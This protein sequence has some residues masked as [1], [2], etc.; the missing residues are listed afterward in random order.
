MGARPHL[1]E[2]DR[3]AAARAAEAINLYWRAR[4]REVNAR[5]NAAG[6]IVSDLSAPAAV[7]AMPRRP[8]PAT[9]FDQN[10]GSDERSGSGKRSGRPA[11]VRAARAAARARI[12]AFLET[13]PAGATLAELCAALSLA[14]TPCYMRLKE[15][16]LEAR[17]EAFS[18]GGRGPIFYRLA[19]ISGRAAAGAFSGNLSGNLSGNPAEKGAG[20]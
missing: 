1:K 4:G 13:R 10:V 14:E 3:A 19:A 2:E 12:A 6:E 7:A 20:A 16:R 18:A 5:V 9:W 17:V 11:A 15:L 8:A